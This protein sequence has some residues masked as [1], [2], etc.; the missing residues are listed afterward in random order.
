MVKT[1]TDKL[2]VE[3]NSINGKKYPDVGYFMFSDIQGNG[4]NNKSVWQVI[5]ANGGVSSA[6][7]LNDFNPRKRC[8][9]IRD[10]IEVSKNLL[11]LN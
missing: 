10:A 7:E 4:A 2:I 8:A 9:K 1:T 5:G 3:L 6:W 11:Q